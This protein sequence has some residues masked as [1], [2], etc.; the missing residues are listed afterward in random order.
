[1][2]CASGFP[3]G[4]TILSR[5]I[6]YTGIDLSPDQ[7]HLAHERYPKWKEY[8]QEAEMLSFLKDLSADSL[9]G[10][11]SMYSIRHLPRRLHVELFEEI[12]RVLQPEGHLL[13]D[14]PNYASEGR[15]TWFDN[16]PMFW[17]SFSLE[18]QQMT[19]KELGFTLLEQ[20]EDVKI[21]NEKE[22]RTLFCLY[23]V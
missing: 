8:F 6:A 10:I 21:F 1:L 17:S 22:E 5:G 4:E 12:L 3:I 20:F 15:G 2:G 7:I 9:D 14:H 13:V 23:Q 11:I 16:Q 19:L 18:W